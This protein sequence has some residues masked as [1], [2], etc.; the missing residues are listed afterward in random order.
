VDTNADNTDMNREGVTGETITA[1][2][3]DYILHL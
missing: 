1:Y 3:P 2:P